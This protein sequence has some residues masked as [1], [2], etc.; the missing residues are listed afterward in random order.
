MA[1]LERNHNLSQRM[2]KELGRGIVC[3]EYSMEDG[4]PSEA[5]LCDEFGVSRTAVREAVKMLSAKGLI[6]SRPRQGIRILP[7]VEWN[8][9][10][11]DVLTWSL[12]GKVSLHV[13]KEYLQMRMGIEPEAAALAARYAKPENIAAIEDALAR[14]KSAFETEDSEAELEADIDFHVGIL[15][16]TGNRFYIHMRDFTRTA[17]KVSI[18]HTTPIKADPMGIVDD[19]GKVL[20]AIKAG[21]AERAKNTMFLLID[22]AITF[23]EQEIAKL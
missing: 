11:S 4:L 12:E 23:I 6:S 20:N 8:L 14:M 5:E 1:V 10:D 15:Y 22:E 3:G 16:A 17:L 21:N 19:H 13:L 7:Q 9:L 18:Q 2:T